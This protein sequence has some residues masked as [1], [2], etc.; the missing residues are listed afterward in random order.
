MIRSEDQCEAGSARVVARA[1]MAIAWTAIALGVAACAGRGEDEVGAAE[2]V[3]IATEHAEDVD[4]FERWASRIAA[5]DTTFPSRAALEEA[6][7]APVRRQEG[8][9][10]A[11][12]ERVGPDPWTLAHPP[13]ATIP[14]D[15]AWRRARLAGLREYE[16]ASAGARRYVRARSETAGGAML[17]VTLAYARAGGVE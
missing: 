14:D 5:T 8:L 9:E 7:F 11:W 17:V 2:A 3:A 16:V 10:G 12:I 6:A 1:A 4:A 13:R 15:L